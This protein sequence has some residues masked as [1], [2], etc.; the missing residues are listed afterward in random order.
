MQV[1]SD[2]QWAR[3]EA[4]IAAVGMRGTRPRKDDRRT[5]EA[6]YLAPRQPL[7]PGGTWQLAPCLPAFSSLGGVWRVGPDDGAR[8]GAGRAETG[9][10]LH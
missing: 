7:D 9:L 4:A 8:G 1:L 2:A 5:I 10:R 6:I 3:F